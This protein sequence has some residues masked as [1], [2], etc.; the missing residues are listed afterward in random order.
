MDD[1][2]V[3]VFA[4]F[5]P[6]PG[7][8]DAVEELL[9][10]MVGHTRAEEGCERY[11]LYRRKGGEF[12]SFHLVERYRDQAALEAHRATDHYV[13]YRAKIADMLAAPI[14]VVVLDPIDA[15]A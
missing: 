10:W 9:R 7:S 2:A 8:E 4:S 1:A 13:E 12:V 15:R 6:N 14:D 3:I 5:R 11:D